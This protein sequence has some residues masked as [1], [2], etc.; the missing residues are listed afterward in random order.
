MDTAVKESKNTQSMSK[1]Y[2][3]Q[4][5]YDELIAMIKSEVAMAF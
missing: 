3:S 2:V 1:F 4:K 5:S